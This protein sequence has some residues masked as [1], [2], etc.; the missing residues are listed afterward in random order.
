MHEC[1]IEHHV[2]CTDPVV[3]Y[4]IVAKEN[5][6]VVKTKKLGRIKIRPQIFINTSSTFNHQILKIRYLAKA[7][8]KIILIIRFVVRITIR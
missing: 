5:V 8:K 6:R 4:K 7:K 1:M 2:V 3:Y